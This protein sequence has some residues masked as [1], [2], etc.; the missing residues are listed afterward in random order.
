MIPQLV[1]LAV[2]AL[3]RHVCAETLSLPKDI[4]SIVPHELISQM[5]T[6]VCLQGLVTPRALAQLL[7]PQFRNIAVPNCIRI[8]DAC[9]H[10][11]TSQCPHLTALNCAPRLYCSAKKNSAAVSAICFAEIKHQSLSFVC[12]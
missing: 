7:Q 11:I 1:E 10:V 8:D 6:Y 4:E 9:V 2:A 5:V 12:G 3:S